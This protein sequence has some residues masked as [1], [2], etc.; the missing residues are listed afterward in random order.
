MSQ[1]DSDLKGK[2]G[3]DRALTLAPLILYGMGVIV[4]AGIYV[5][6]GAV[7]QRAGAAAPFSFFLA[8]VSAALT[9]LC[10][11]ELASRFP[12]ASGAAGFVGHGFR[13]DIASGIATLAITAAT[14]VAAASIA[15]GAAVYWREIVAI[16]PWLIT[17][18]VIAVN[19]AIAIYGVKTSV[20]LAAIIGAIEILGLGAAVAA[21]LYLAPD[22]KIEA[23]LPTA[24]DG[25]LGVLDGAF[26]A[27]FAFIG[28]E[29]LV[30]MA[31]EVKDPTRTVPAGIVGAVAASTALYVLVAV[32]VVLAERSGGNPLLGLFEGK[33][34]LVFSI[35]GSVSIAN[36]VLVEIV[37]LSRLFYGMARAGLLPRAMGRVETFTRTPVIATLAAGAIILA[38]ALLAPFERLLTAANAI[39][40]M[41]FLM[42]DLSLLLVKRRQPSPRPAFCAPGWVPPAA[43]AGTLILLL[44]GARG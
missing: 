28:F 19:T 3:L 12:E 15:H 16:D 42:V 13:S 4:G 1:A 22:Y 27:Y 43:I 41:I 21:G 38:T 34:A 25:W 9:G 35:I 36:G 6:L 44:A 33:S 26:I 39:T 11:A 32:S 40:L 2:D 17:A 10:Y 8:G 23:L 31:E 7:I 18:L 24:V 5:A 29:T 20:G 14:A 30:N 37:M